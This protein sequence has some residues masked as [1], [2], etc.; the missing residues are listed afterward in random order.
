MPSQGGS[1]KPRSDGWT[2][3]SLET[4]RQTRADLADYADANEDAL[5]AERRAARIEAVERA[6]APLNKRILHSRKRFRLRRAA[7]KNAR[8]ARKANRG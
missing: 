8:A 2:E 4:L 3:A 5:R 6:T 1:V 7:A